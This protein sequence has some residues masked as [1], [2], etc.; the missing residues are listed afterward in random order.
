MKCDYCNRPS[1]VHQTEICNGKMVE[2]NFCEQCAA[3]IGLQA[4]KGD[5]PINELL[6]KFVMAHSGIQAEQPTNCEQCGMTWAEFRQSGLMGC[7][8]DYDTFDANLAPLI[9]RAHEGATHHI[10]KI[11]ATQ[12]P[13]E[14][15]KH[16]TVDLTR[17]RKELQRAVEAEDYETA[18][19]IRDRIKL[20]EIE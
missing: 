6:T 18:A 14:T 9:Q 11:P 1:T 7:P 10:G 12:P 20:A 17:L 3:K 5:T 16:K 2:K 15:P 4:A 13:G 19:K 8:A